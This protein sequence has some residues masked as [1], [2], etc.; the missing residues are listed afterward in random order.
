MS[1]KLYK[2]GC[3]P[4]AKRDTSIIVSKKVRDIIKARAKKDNRTMQWIIEDAI[5]K[6]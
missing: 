6:Y 4:T 1:W 5:R 2:G 3:M